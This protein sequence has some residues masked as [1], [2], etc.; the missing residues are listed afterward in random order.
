MKGINRLAKLLKILNNQKK[1][2]KIVS[3]C[4]FKMIILFF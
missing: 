2:N 1:M 4:F 3:F